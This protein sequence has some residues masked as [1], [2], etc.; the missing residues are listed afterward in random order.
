MTARAPARLALAAVLALLGCKGCSEHAPPDASMLGR[1][2]DPYKQMPPRSSELDWE[3]AVHVLEY[4]GED[5]GYGKVPA[6]VLQLHRGEAW[7]HRLAML[8]A[9]GGTRQ[10]ALAHKDLVDTLVESTHLPAD[11]RYRI[12]LSEGREQDW[13]DEAKDNDDAQ[14]RGLLAEITWCL[15]ALGAA[16]P[17]SGY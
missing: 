6:G 7:A 2:G 10:L 1:I 5:A 17:D 4:V 14:R 3:R 16:T 11:V 13:A 15:Y 12:K 8:L 9:N